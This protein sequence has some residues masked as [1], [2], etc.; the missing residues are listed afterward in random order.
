MQCKNAQH[1]GVLSLKFT[2]EQK[3]SF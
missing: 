1:L 2:T 3:L